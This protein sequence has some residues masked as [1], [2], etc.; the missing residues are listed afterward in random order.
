MQVTPRADRELHSKLPID[1]D[2]KILAIYKHHW[3]VYAATWMV[4][5]V[6]ILLILGVAL[7]LSMGLGN[8]SESPLA[9]HQMQIMGA[10]AFL[11]V[12][13]A[14]GTFVPVYLRSQEQV[15]LTEEALLQVLQPTLFSSKID[16]VGLQ[17]I[18][19]VSVTQDFF[20]TMFGFGHITVETPGE[21]NNYRFSTLPNPHMTAREI[22]EAH[23]NYEAAL[24]GGHLKTTLGTAPAQAQQI[25]PEQYRQFLQYQQMVAQQQAQQQG[26]QPPVQ[27]QTSQS[28]QQ[29]LPG[30]DP[31]F[32][33]QQKQ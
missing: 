12:F 28:S 13:V 5:A 27:G 1:N 22:S 26:G 23:E 32:P 29:D 21:Q 3:F 17:H 31:T 10:A 8:N 33:D 19:D 24:Q 30:Q 11:C 6:M 25:D 9:G 4:G 14:L 7:A 20:G 16:Q 2:E 18:A 15:V